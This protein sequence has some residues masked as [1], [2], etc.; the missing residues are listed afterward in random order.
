MLLNMKLMLLAF[1][2]GTS[3]YK[4]FI[5]N[6]DEKYRAIVSFVNLTESKNVICG[7]ELSLC[8]FHGNEFVNVPV[9]VHYYWLPSFS[10]EY[11]H[12]ILCRSN[13]VRLNNLWSVL[14]NIHSFSVCWPGS[15]H[16]NKIRCKV[17]KS[18]CF[19]CISI[20]F[21]SCRG[22]SLE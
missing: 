6:S 14:C 1:T 13:E 18:D 15:T 7:L 2:W 20:S 11:L 9:G 10:T 12:S 19:L 21:S 17:I 16:V 8:C 22:S 4:G 5:S 3:S